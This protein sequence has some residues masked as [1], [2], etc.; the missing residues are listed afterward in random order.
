M[1][2]NLRSMR[3]HASACATAAV[4]L[5]QPGFGLALSRAF[6]VLETICLS[7][8]NSPAARSPG[9]CPGV[10]AANIHIDNPR[11]FFHQALPGQD[12]A[13]AGMSRRPGELR[14]VPR[15]WGVSAFYAPEFVVL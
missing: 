9:R 1:T 15:N 14:S 11:A 10:E 3:P 12:M 2:G 5:A 4:R 13:K 6:S 8:R 7:S